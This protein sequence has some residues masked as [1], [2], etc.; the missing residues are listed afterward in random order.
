MEPATRWE[1]GTAS[2]AMATARLVR[3]AARPR[4]ALSNA[5]GLVRNVFAVCT[6]AP[7]AA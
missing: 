6:V 3:S 4:P 5:Q 7:A 2:R 1:P